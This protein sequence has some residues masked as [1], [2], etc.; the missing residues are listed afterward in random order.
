MSD[1]APKCWNIM[2]QNCTA[3]LADVETRDKQ[4]DSKE[5][6]FFKI[7]AAV[8]LQAWAAR[9]AAL[10]SLGSGVVE[11]PPL[12]VT[13]IKSRLAHADSKA[14]I[15]ATMGQGDVSAGDF[16]TLT[17]GMDTGVG[18][19]MND[20]LL[21]TGGGPFGGTFAHPPIWPDAQTWGWPTT[22]FHSMMGQGW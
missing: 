13:Q 2:N 22:G 5:H 18:F 17:T 15:D 4:S 9:E 6:A 16:D 3:R 8:V 14:H 11:E 21:D 19:N 7:F 20:D 1:S 12:I 10:A